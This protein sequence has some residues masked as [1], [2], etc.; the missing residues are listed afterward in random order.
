MHLQRGPLVEDEGDDVLCAAQ[1]GGEGQVHEHEEEEEGPEGR[2]GHLQDG[3]RV[4]HEGQLD[5]L[6]DH[7]LDGLV[8]RLREEAQHAEHDEAGVDRGQRVEHGDEDGVAE[9]VVVELVERGQDDLVGAG[10]QFSRLWPFFG[11]LL[12]PFFGPFFCPIKLGTEL[13]FK[14]A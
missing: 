7:L 1:A 13:P 3:A 2:H 10:G 4:R 14:T 6:R 9:G 12:G 5:P 11:P 8:R